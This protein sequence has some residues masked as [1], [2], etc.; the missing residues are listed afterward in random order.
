MTMMMLMAILE[1]LDID[2]RVEDNVV[3]GL[4]MEILAA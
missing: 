3:L 1:L 2:D 4:M